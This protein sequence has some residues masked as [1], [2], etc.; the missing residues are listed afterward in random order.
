VYGWRARIGFIAPSRGDTFNYEFYKIVPEGVVLI[1]S[2]MTFFT[3]TK[4]TAEQ[5]MKNL[6]KFSLDLARVGVDYMYLGGTALF[7]YKGVGSDLEVIERIE[8]LTGV[9]A[10]TSV[11]AEMQALRKL[12]IKK[13]VH[14]SPHRDEVIAKTKAFL[15]A[16]GFEVLNSRGLQILENAEFAK[17]PAFEVYKFAKKSFLETPDADGLF[18]SCPRWPTIY[19]IAKLEA[20]LKVPVVCTTAAYIYAAFDRLKIGGPI[21][22]FGKL[23]ELL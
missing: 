23:L 6:E 16:S 15:N 5:A 9:P 10:T 11:T 18:I 17:I 20:D 22:G 13:I 7:T 3:L 8:S 4:E 14:I 2:G 12:N 1:M 19:S 21:T